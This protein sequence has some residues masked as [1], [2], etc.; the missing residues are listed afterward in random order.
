MLH[1]A[2]RDCCNLHATQKAAYICVYGA[3]SQKGLLTAYGESITYDAIG[4]PT[5][6]YNGNRRIW[7]MEYNASGICTKQGTKE[8]IGN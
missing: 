6:C 2:K 1:F 4:N 3:A 8:K 5:G 7:E